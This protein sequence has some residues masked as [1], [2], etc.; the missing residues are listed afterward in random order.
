VFGDLA[1]EILKGRTCRSCYGP[2]RFGFF[3]SDIS[4]PPHVH[5]RR[6]RDKAKFWLSPAVRMQA[7]KGFADHELVELRKHVSANR[8]FFIERWNEYFEV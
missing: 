8:T 3:A 1:C 5:V 4:E 2:Y 6:G 7:S